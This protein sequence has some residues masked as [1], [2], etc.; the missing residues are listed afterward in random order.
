[1]KSDGISM[2][3]NLQTIYEEANRSL[4]KD[5][6]PFNYELKSSIIKA[7]NNAM[8]QLTAYAEVVKTASELAIVN[9]ILQAEKTAALDEL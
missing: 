5:K 1:M 8:H 6:E 9:G 2:A 7:I 3:Q 4:L